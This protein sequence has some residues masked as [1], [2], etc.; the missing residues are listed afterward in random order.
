MG[1]RRSPGSYREALQ[2]RPYPGV[3]I[4][5]K[6][7]LAPLSERA[8]ES[9]LEAIGEYVSAS[10]YSD[11]VFVSGMDK[12]SSSARVCAKVESWS[13]GDC[14]DR[15]GLSGACDIRMGTPQLPA[16]EDAMEDTPDD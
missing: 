9:T 16:I 8:G 13:A 11:M 15:A 6:G 3:S 4:E 12:M 2:D 10:S 1:P 14:V 5:S 7:T